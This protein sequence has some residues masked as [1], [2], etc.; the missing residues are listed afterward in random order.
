MFDDEERKRAGMVVGSVLDRQ[1]KIGSG[2]DP[3]SLMKQLTD[4]F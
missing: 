3:F 4:T 2:D 1:N